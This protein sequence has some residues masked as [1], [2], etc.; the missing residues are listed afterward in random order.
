[1]VV[2]TPLRIHDFMGP[3]SSQIYRNNYQGKKSYCRISL[4]YQPDSSIPD[5]ADLV[6][7]EDTNYPFVKVIP[8]KYGSG[9]VDVFWSLFNISHGYAYDMASEIVLKYDVNPGDSILLSGHSGGVQRNI[10]AT[11][12]FI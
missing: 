11:R 3:L 12:I 5:T 9:I 10:A 1:M 8:Y 4:T 2:V 7:Q 6:I